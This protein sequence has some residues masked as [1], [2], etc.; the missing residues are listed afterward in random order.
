MADLRFEL[1][2]V[3][4]V[5]LIIKLYFLVTGTGFFIFLGFTFI[6]Y[7]MDITYSS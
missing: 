7:K 3:K 6:I 4:P 1:D 2:T 5:L